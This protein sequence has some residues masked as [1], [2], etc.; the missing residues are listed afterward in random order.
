MPTK[1]GSV[2]IDITANTSKL[3][4]TLSDAGSRVRQF[5]HGAVS[6]V[7]AT[8]AALRVM[9]GGFTGNLRAAE[10]FLASVVGLGPI[11]K[12]AFPVVGGI[13]FLGLMGKLGSEVYKFFNEL[14]DAPEKASAAWNNLLSPIKTS[15][16]E[17][18]LANAKLERD[19]AKL[20]GK[21]ENGLKIALAEAKVEADHLFD[22]LEKDLSAMNKLLS[23]QSAGALQK[24]LTTGSP[25]DSGTSAAL[26]HVLGGDSSLGGFYAEIQKLRNEESKQ[27]D[28]I[29][30]VKPQTSEL[31]I[32]LAGTSTNPEELAKNA[33]NSI[34]KHFDS[35]ISE[36]YK[37]L[38]Q[39]LG[40]VLASTDMSA[41]DR[42]TLEH[43]Q[44]FAQ[45]EVDRIAKT[46]LNSTL[47]Q[48]KA[49]DAAGAH[50]EKLTKPIEDAIRDLKAQL[51]GLQELTKAV[52]GT[53]AEQ[54][55]AKTMELWQKKIAELDNA[56]G[57]HKGL[58]TALY[59]AQIKSLESSI[60]QTEVDTASK[61]LFDETNKSIQERITALRELAAA[62]GANYDAAKQAFV[63]TE[64]AKAL[65]EHQNDPAW[66]QKYAGNIAGIQ[67]GFGA[68][69]DA[70][71]NAQAQKTL[72]ALQQQITLES[73]MASV[74]S[75]GAEAVRRAE[76]AQKVLDIQRTYSADAAD[77]LIAREIELLNA[78]EKN[79]SQERLFGLN[80]Q[81]A[82]N[83]NITG[84]QFGGTDAIRQAELQN[85][86]TEA[87]ARGA[88]QDEIAAITLEA[89][90]K[91]YGEI[92]AEAA[93]LVTADKDRMNTLDREID[94]IQT[95]IALKGQTLAATTALKNLEDQRL[96]LAAQIEL[97]QN[98]ALAGVHA[99]FLE[100]QTQAEKTSKIIYDALNSSVEKVSDNLAAMLTQK[101]PKGGWGETWSK[102]FIG[103][104]DDITKNTLHSGI[105]QGLG[106][107][108]KAFP[109]LPGLSKIA[110]GKPDGTQNNPLWVRIVGALGGVGASS[111][112]S[113]GNLGDIIGRL[114]KTGSDDGE[115]D[116]PGVFGG[117]QGILST[118]FSLLPHLASGGDT[119]P[120]NAYGVGEAGPEIFTPKVPGRITPLNQI[121][122]GAGGGMH[123][124]NTID[125]RGAALGVENRIAQGID[126]AHTSAIQHAVRATNERSL[127]TPQ[128]S[129]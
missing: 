75:Q 1:A 66:Q 125:A 118:V 55:A 24:L 82:N 85:Q 16:D 99:F 97:Q 4:T 111:G 119:I 35:I 39:G 94:A 105:Q 12:A 64:T 5:S 113:S 29:K 126:A 62:T 124:Y 36:K 22:S 83:R 17:L 117:S 65:K 60:V 53:E 77:K 50:N 121:G 6:D 79:A 127:R 72:F 91:Y 92:V 42:E 73:A 10:R 47:T 81:I 102:T 103:I 98:D 74:Q 100:M 11:L 31:G 54:V 38:A 14:Q 112:A 34:S 90:T 58:L 48:K 108:G 107:L 61:K 18:D 45:L 122:Y 63:T 67:G 44:R 37:A 84:A 128:R 23:E 96:R 101:R 115:S 15:V 89:Q 27:L 59:Q 78:K 32:H 51:S 93:K 57:N 21:R 33:A 109:S 20:E 95:E 71:N 2:V 8:S 28:S 9:E 88:S 19:I 106:A 26:K 123:I 116:S 7:Q 49:E 69:F 76:L 25:F 43:A 30:T 41:F 120:G 114:G 52:G 80:Q 104:G 56:L 70:E 3:N 68:Q 46:E 40:N 86:I 110:Q 13:A 129:R 87:K